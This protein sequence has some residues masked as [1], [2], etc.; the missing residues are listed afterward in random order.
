[1]KR[2]LAFDTSGPSLS[3][4]LLADTKLIFECTQQTGLTH[5]DRL[6][7]M[8]DAA[9]QTGGCTAADIDCFAVTVG[10]GSFTGVRI[11]VATA[12]ALAHA[13]GKPCIGINALEA[14]AH[15]AGLFDGMVCAMQDARAGQVYC[16]A[17][18]AGQ[19]VMGDVAEKLDILLPQLANEESCCFVGDGAA[20]HR[21]IIEAVMGE[22][23][24]FAP[25]DRMMIHAGSVALLAAQRPELAVSF[26]ELLPYYLRAPQAERERL[27]REENHG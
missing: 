24:V 3:V 7:P 1:M 20:A 23:A 16:A 2:I 17:F 13:T 27:A 18:C 9:L 25:A 8:I 26:R 6:M 14:M 15:T 22:K 12:K 4:A 10:P 19:R 11:G 5:S 21:E